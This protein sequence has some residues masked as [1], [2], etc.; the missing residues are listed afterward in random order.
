MFAAQQILALVTL[1]AAKFLGAL[2]AF[3]LLAPPAQ[4]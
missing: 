1:P 3:P 4:K 2:L